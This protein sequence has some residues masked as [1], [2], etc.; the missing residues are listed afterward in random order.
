MSAAHDVMNYGYMI[1]SDR[2]V[3]FQAF[4]GR[5]S[6]TQIIACVRRLWNDPAYSKTY[7]G[8]VDI[9]RMTPSAGLDDL[10]GLVDFLKSETQTST[11]RWA[12]ITSSPAATAGSMVYKRIMAGRHVFE[13]FST[14]ESACEFLQLEITERPAIPF[15]PDMGGAEPTPSVVI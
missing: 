5:F 6:L 13:V 12:V 4:E 7:P 10:N 15:L 11:S 14:W 3:I 9:S 2:K 1:D 8:I